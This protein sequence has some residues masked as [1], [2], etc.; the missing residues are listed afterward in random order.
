[1]LLCLVRAFSASWCRLRHES[2]LLVSPYSSDVTITCRFSDHVSFF[3]VY[4]DCLHPVN[5]KSGLESVGPLIKKM[6]SVK[7]FS[8]IGDANVR[9]NMTGLNVASREVMKAAQVIDYVGLTPFAS[10]LQEIR[11]ESSVIIIAAI[12]DLLLSGGDCGTIASSIDPVLDSFFATISC[13]C[14]AHPSQQ[15]RIFGIFYSTLLGYQ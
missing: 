4:F 9:R 2:S 14:V 12:T 1:M 7:R 3:V 6:S 11:S 10:A 13:Y 5:F 15:V 8:I